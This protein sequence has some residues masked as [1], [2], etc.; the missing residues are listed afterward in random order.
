MTI[1]TIFLCARSLAYYVYLFI[2]KEGGLHGLI[3]K[4]YQK[5]CQ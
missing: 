5:R 3:L 1:G 4:Y 2:I